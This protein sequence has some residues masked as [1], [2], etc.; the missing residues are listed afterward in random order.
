VGLGLSRV[1]AIYLGHVDTPFTIKDE[2]NQL[3]AQVR[4]SGLFLEEDGGVG[5]VQQVDL[6]A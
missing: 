2:S 3:L 1:G 5:S 6:M 4:D